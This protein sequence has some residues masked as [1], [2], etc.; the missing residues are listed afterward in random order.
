MA[1]RIS[2]R[3]KSKDTLLTEFVRFKLAEDE[4][5]IRQALKLIYSGQTVDEK[6]MRKTIYKNLRGFSKPDAERIADV[7][8]EYKLLGGKLTRNTLANIQ[9]FIPKYAKQMY[10]RFP[11]IR[12]MAEDELMNPVTRGR[13][14]IPDKYWDIMQDSGGHRRELGEKELVFSSDD[15]AVKELV[16]I[17]KS[18]VADWPDKVEKGGLRKEM[19]LDENESLEDQTSPSAVASFFN[20][21][22][23][24]GKGMVM[25]AINSNK[26][27][28][29]WQKVHSMIKK[30]QENA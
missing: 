30:D 2:G 4:Y 9:K 20:S 12:R 3:R 6:K 16:K 21:A 17:A 13:F 24:E 25:F 19:G 15:R 10:K 18:L 7:I 29:F 1:I 22:D 14:E 11:E 23:K 5:W 26:D 8:I 28:S 27:N